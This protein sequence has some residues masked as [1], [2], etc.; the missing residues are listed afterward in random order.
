MATAA[1]II[2]HSNEMQ[3][4]GTVQKSPAGVGEIRQTRA[5]LTTA[6]APRRFPITGEIRLTP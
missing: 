3:L 6:R 2:G 5:G 1:V 4:H